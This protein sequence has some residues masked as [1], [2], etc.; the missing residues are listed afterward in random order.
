MEQDKEWRVQRM[1]GDRGW[2]GIRD[3]QGMEGDK[4]WSRIKGW[5]RT[6][7]GEYKRWREKKD[8]AGQGMKGMGWSGTGDGRKQRIEQNRGWSRTRGE[9]RVI[10]RI[11]KGRS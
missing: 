6:R 1:K 10:P 4:G 7:N 11:V 3:G 9:G 8:G 5:N 2:S